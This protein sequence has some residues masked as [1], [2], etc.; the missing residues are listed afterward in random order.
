MALG[1]RKRQGNEEAVALTLPF[2]QGLSL[3]PAN[4]PVQEVEF[5]VIL[6]GVLLFVGSSARLEG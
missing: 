3:W 2:P 5:R 4:I 6:A 1:E